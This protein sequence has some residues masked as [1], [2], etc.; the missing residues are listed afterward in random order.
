M[1]LNGK[2]LEAAE[3]WWSLS[4]VAGRGMG[5]GT[6]FDGRGCQVWSWNNN[7]YANT[8]LSHLKLCAASRDS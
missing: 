7:V 2:L 4:A 3:I 5:R 1:G 6:E 8:A